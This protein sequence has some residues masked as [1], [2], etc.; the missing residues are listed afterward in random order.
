M[1]EVE[2]EVQGL[3]DAGFAAASE[4]AERLRRDLIATRAGVDVDGK[5]LLVGT[6]DDVIR[7][8]EL[9]RVHYRQV[10]VA[11]WREGAS[12]GDWAQ[13]YRHTQGMRGLD[14]VAATVHI[15]IEEE[16]KRRFGLDIRG[17]FQRSR[18][19]LAD[20]EGHVLDASAERGAP[21]RRSG[22]ADLKS[23]HRRAGMLPA[24]GTDGRD[25]AVEPS[26]RRQASERSTPSP[27]PAPQATSDRPLPAAAGPRLVPAAPGSHRVERWPTPVGRPDESAA[28][29]LN[30]WRQRSGAEEAG[31]SPRPGAPAPVPPGDG[32]VGSADVSFDLDV[33]VRSWLL[34]RWCPREVP[35]WCARWWLH[36]GAVSRLDA[37]WQAW[38]LLGSSVDGLG[39]SI[40]WREHADYHLAVV[41]S[42]N[43]PLAACDQR[44]GHHQVGEMLPAVARPACGP[45]DP[46]DPSHEAERATVARLER[47]S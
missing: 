21:Q 29:L 35:R 2:P 30:A 43:G 13:A 14:P 10:G 6:H 41:T 37:I 25:E 47:R 38:K 46:A 4:H 45:I 28:P 20:H 7:V 44:Q 8:L 11:V 24:P 22:R 31:T 18:T 5:T 19:R 39:L 27:T 26:P 17:C 32:D 42:E 9:A 3:L 40:W 36:P 15:R 16:V 12:L 23:D 34:P 33:W 1:G